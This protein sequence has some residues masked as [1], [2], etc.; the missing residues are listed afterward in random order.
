MPHT[1]YRRAQC[2]EELLWL[3]CTSVILFMLMVV[4]G[5]SENNFLS[6][7]HVCN[8]KSI[9]NSSDTGFSQSLGMRPS[10]RDLCRWQVGSPT[11]WEAEW[12]VMDES[13]LPGCSVPALPAASVCL[14]SLVKQ[15][16][17]HRSGGRGTPQ[18]ILY[19]VSIDFEGGMIG[20]Y[21]PFP[22]ALGI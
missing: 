14:K 13:C 19:A 12:T 3:L 1:T 6:G 2:N 21:H 10:L 5:L 16:G 4:S 11:L 20:I 17:Q 18:L 15:K 8:M 22:E 7:R 9:G